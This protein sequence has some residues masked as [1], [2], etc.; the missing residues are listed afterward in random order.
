MRATEFTVHNTQRFEIF[1]RKRK[2]RF[3]LWT[4]GPI[5][6]HRVVLDHHL[7]HD[8]IE[9]HLEYAEPGDLS[10][11]KAA[12]SEIPTERRPGATE[13]E[14]TIRLGTFWDFDDA[15]L[16][17]MEA[18]ARHAV[19]LP[20]ASQPSPR[21]VVGHVGSI[22]FLSTN[23]ADTRA[24]KAGMLGQ[25]TDGEVTMD[26]QP[27]HRLVWSCTNPR[28]QLN[29]SQRT[30]GFTR[31]WS[32]SLWSRPVEHGR[33]MWHTRRCSTGQRQRVAHF[34][35]RHATPSGRSVRESWS[36]FG[37]YLTPSSRTTPPT[38]P[39]PPSMTTW[40]G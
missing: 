13:A 4:V 11:R 16:D 25:W 23:G 21:S 12:P 10:W 7:T 3:E 31:S 32:F 17:K 29:V 5:K 28:H 15:Q 26:L 6:R 9:A 30:H 8:D 18:L 40:A 1:V 27:N 24:A 14:Q 33:L 34:Q 38:P 35:Q 22:G 2:N 36:A 20:Q 19:G 39:T 37:C